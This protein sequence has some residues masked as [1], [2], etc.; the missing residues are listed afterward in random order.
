MC[1]CTNNGIIYIIQY[2]CLLLWI[3]VGY[4]INDYLYKWISLKQE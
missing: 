3:Y 2:L 4:I 1:K